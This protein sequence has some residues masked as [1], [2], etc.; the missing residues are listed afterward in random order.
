M[1]RWRGLPVRWRLPGWDLLLEWD[2]LWRKVIRGA[3]VA[4]R[5]LLVG[6]HATDSGEMCAS[7]LS[8]VHTNS[9]GADRRDLHR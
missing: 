2:L 1:L 3:T 7:T 9:D 5:G 6:V 4:G 8:H